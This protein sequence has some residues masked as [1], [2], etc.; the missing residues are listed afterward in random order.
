[1]P[2]SSISRK[3]LL[4][5]P[6]RICSRHFSTKITDT[7]VSVVP[8]INLPERSMIFYEELLPRLRRRYVF[9]SETGYEDIDIDKLEPN[10][11]LISPYANPLPCD[12]PGCRYKSSDVSLFSGRYVK[13]FSIPSNS[14]DYGRWHKAIQNGIGLPSTFE[15]HLPEA[16]H[17]PSVFRKLSVE[18]VNPKL[19]QLG[20]VCLTT[21]AIATCSNAVIDTVCVPFPKPDDDL[22]HRWIDALAIDDESNETKFICL[23]HFSL[24]FLVRFEQQIARVAGEMG[25]LD[26]CGDQRLKRRHENIEEEVKKNR[27]DAQE[28]APD[29]YPTNNGGERSEQEKSCCVESRRIGET[30]EQI[31][32]KARVVERVVAQLQITC[33][34]HYD[35]KGEFNHYMKFQLFDILS[36]LRSQ[37]GVVHSLRQ[38][39]EDSVKDPDKL[40]WAID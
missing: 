11:I 1:M 34:N 31:E 39:L 4:D 3:K 25:E 2:I 22:Y 19:S 10:G 37:K 24:F 21:C 16:G 32:M 23:R 8:D 13:M 17:D 5:F 7:S 9:L 20:P 14:A 36:E 27:L 15:F 28:N 12:V 29:L 38:R 40:R 6:F 33:K 18:G 26:F 30:V 35:N